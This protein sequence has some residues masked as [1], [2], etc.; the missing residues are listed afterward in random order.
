MGFLQ[1]HFSIKNICL[2]LI[3]IRLFYLT[4]TDKEFS[5]LKIDFFSVS[6]RKAFPEV[7]L[8]TKAF[9][10]SFFLHQIPLNHNNF[11]Y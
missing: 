11:N 2:Q 9:A 6:N 1:I 3:F 10:K 5:H 8:N 4:A 7:I